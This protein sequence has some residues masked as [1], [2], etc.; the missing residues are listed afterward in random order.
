MSGLSAVFVCRRP[1]LYSLVSVIGYQ[2]LTQM[3]FDIGVGDS[4][5]TGS[6]C[7]ELLVI[8]WPQTGLYMI[9]LSVYLSKN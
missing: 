1:L 4:V 3:C 5:N 9:C 7:R 6:L 8:G 2:F